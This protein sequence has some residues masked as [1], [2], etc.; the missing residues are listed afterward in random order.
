MILYFSVSNFRAIRNDMPLSMSAGRFKSAIRHRSFPTEFSNIPCLL[1]A[2]AIYG[3]NGSGK[4]TL[5][6]AL[7]LMQDIVLRSFKDNDAETLSRVDPY[8]YDPELIK[9]PSTFEISFIENDVQYVYGFSCD[10]TAIHDEW[11]HVK[12][13]SGRWREAYSRSIVDG[14][15]EWHFSPFFKSSRQVTTWRESTR[16][17]A[18]FLSTANHLNSE[19]LKP[20]FRWL[21]YR[22][23]VISASEGLGIEVTSAA[24]KNDKRK[25][26]LLDFLRFADPTVTEIEV[27]ERSMEDF[28]VLNMFSEEVRSKISEAIKNLPAFEVTLHHVNAEGNRISLSLDEESDG[29]KTMYRLAYPFAQSVSNNF[30]LVIDEIDRSL[31][32][33]L[34]S[35]LISKIS[36]PDDIGCRAQI[37]FTAHDTTLM[38]PDILGRDQIWFIENVGGCGT[39]LIPLADYKPRK[40]EAIQRSYLHGRYGGIPTSRAL[41]F[42]NAE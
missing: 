1:R 37:I 11:L 6:Q 28:D 19:E 25:D 3:A 16:E 38:S 17:N 31:H 2:A 18:L 10:K 5:I 32:S 14:K 26:D 34:L 24:I 23:R 12:N 35:F 29:T 20:V 15:T 9:K 41:T 7:D 30:V 13:K 22:L 4:S 36:N 39:Q 33:L 27:K 21:S 40:S 42:K 8:R